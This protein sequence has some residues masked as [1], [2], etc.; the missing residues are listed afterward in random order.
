M[1]FRPIPFRSFVLVL[2]ILLSIGGTA[3]ANDGAVTVV[4]WNVESGDANIQTIA[5]KAGR[6]TGV[7]ILGLSEV[8]AELWSHS[9]SGALTR[10]EREIFKAVTG[11]TGRSDRLAVVYDDSELDLI[12]VDELH[13][14]N[15][16][17]RVRSP[18]VCH[19]RHTESDTPFLFCVNHLYRSRDAERHEQARQLNEWIKQQSMPV[20][21]GGDMN[22][23]WSVANN[24]QHRDKGFDN[25]TSGG[26]VNWVRPANIIKTHSSNYNSILDFIFVTPNGPWKIESAEIIVEDGDFPD[27]GWTSDHRPVS[28]VFRIDSGA[29]SKA[30]TGTAT[31]PPP[32]QQSVSQLQSALSN[33]E[34]AIES[35]QAET[36]KL[37]EQDPRE[38]SL[39]RSIFGRLERMRRDAESIKE[40]IEERLG[41][42][43]SSN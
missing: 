24:G 12:G 16:G 36:E 34:Q 32:Q 14:I 35:L 17:G 4:M 31:T 38:R 41:D 22:F 13:D 27:T 21:V 20:I 42:S 11:T 23:D 43:D 28:A 15:P 8:E 5:E 33:L 29:P 25:L 2:G 18:L 40:L 6:F 7:D 10:A 3:S 1:S 39:R 30:P 37:N 19:F 26:V 9:I